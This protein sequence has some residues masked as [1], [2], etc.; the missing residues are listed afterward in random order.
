MPFVSNLILIRNEFDTNPAPSRAIQFEEKDPLPHTQGQTVLLNRNYRAISQ[1]YGS[2]MGMG[3]AFT[4]VMPVA[5]TLWSYI[6]QKIQYVCHQSCIR[7]IHSQSS[8]CMKSIN[9]ADSILYTAIQKSLFYMS[10]NVHSIHWF[11]GINLD[12]NPPQFSGIDPNSNQI[13]Q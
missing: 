2:K 3:I 10:C 11:F 12:H 8:S 7:L 9:Q 1:Q 13:H 5:C 4:M 6:F